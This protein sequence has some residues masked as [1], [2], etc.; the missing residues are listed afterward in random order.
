MDYYYEYF[1]K[2]FRLA[3]DPTLYRSAPILHRTTNEPPSYFFF[4]FSKSSTC[5]LAFTSS[6]LT[7]LYIP[8]VPP[9]AY[10]A[11]L[12]PISLP[13]DRIRTNG[14]NT[15]PTILRTWC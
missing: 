15:H 7:L 4:R 8:K 6:M 13:V 5:V 12:R 2:Y 11:A 9:L 1:Y 14:W 3:S 10:P